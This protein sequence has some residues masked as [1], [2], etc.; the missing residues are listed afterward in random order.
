[1]RE[2]LTQT[3]GKK[4]D[5]WIS[6][7]H[8]HDA[9]LMD[10]TDFTPASSTKSRENSQ[11]SASNQPTSNE[12]NQRQSAT[13]GISTMPEETSKDTKAGIAAPDRLEPVTGISANQLSIAEQMKNA[14]SQYSSSTA[15]ASTSVPK[16]E[17]KPIQPMVEVIEILSSDDESLEIFD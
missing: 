1:M 12:R 10:D 2:L 15:S 8:F 6:K 4:I 9:L 11:A 13:N 3:P 7:Y 16:R 14:W 17:R 5:N